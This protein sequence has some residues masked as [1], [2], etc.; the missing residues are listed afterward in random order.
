MKKWMIA[1]MVM[2]GIFLFGPDYAP[3]QV[4]AAVIPKDQ[5]SKLIWF[6]DSR[7][8]FLGETVY[9]Y[10]AKKGVCPATILARHVVARRTSMSGWANGTGYKQLSKR[11]KK[12]PDAVVIFN[13]GVNDIGRG[14]DHRDSY[15]RLLQKIHKKFPQVQLYFMSVNPV[16]ASS[17][18]PYAKNSW[19]A[20]QVNQ[21]IASFNSYMKKHL[22][23]EYG[24]IN[25]NRKVK[26]RYRDG[27]HYTGQTYK[28]IAR[29][30]TGKKKL[31]K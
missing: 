25:T 1:L 20:R 11:L 7:T 30:V 26:F 13:F 29:Y 10:K 28:E 24:Y 12:H 4:Q 5:V 31:K 15:R 22:P 6:G 8:V 9:G 3:R 21:K 23:K 18:N 17:Q 14:S 27:L 2:I 19:K 16:S